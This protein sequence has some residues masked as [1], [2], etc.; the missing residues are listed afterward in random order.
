MAVAIKRSALLWLIFLQT[1]ASAAYVPQELMVR[2]AATSSGCILLQGS[3]LKCWGYNSHG[4]LGLGDTDNR[5]DSSSSMIAVAPVLD[6]GGTPTHVCTGELHACA[7]LDNSTL[8][9]WGHGSEGQTGQGDQLNRGDAAGEMGENLPAVDV[10]SGRTVS[11]VACGDTWT[12]MVLDN[13]AVK[14][15]GRG[16][17]ERIGNGLWPHMMGHAPEYIGDHLPEVNL[18]TT[19]T[20]VFASFWHSC[21]ILTDGSAK[22]WGRPDNGMLG[23]NGQARLGFDTIDV[24][25]GRTVTQMALAEYA[26]CVGE[27]LRT[28]F[29]L[30][31]CPGIWRHA[32]PSQH[33]CSSR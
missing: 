9:C 15:M 14:C 30:Q 27:V 2:S 3:E 1:L 29:R 7:V 18:G 25:S 16:H 20:D 13:G 22:C 28:W 10:G 8:K 11:K 12:C 19:A 32:E 33:R 26:T 23:K 4:Q 21:A 17:Y 5:G 31:G 24:G 6:L